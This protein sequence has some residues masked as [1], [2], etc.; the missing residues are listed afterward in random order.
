MS[1][2]VDWQILDRMKG[3]SIIIE[4]F[5]RDQLSDNAYD[6]TVSRHFWRYPNKAGGEYRY[7]DADI[8]GYILVQAGERILGASREY[9][10]GRVANGV[11]VNTHLQAT[12]TA[13][14]RGWGA[15]DD[16]GWGNVGYTKP[17]TL[18]IT[19]RAP[20]AERLPVGA[21]IAQIAFAEVAVP[22]N[23]YGKDHGQYQHEGEEWTPE[24]MLP[25]PLKVRK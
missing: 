7:V 12:S 6:L 15:C 11:A 5:H 10:G 22:T 25:G 1:L 16:A 17:W 14:R 19:N 18:E 2:L 9:A 20:Y 21:I 3:G 23:V 13:G 4:P 24:M 8:D